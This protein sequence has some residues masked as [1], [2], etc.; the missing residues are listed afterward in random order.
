MSQTLNF[1]VDHSR[2]NHEQAS[3][4][5]KW[6]VEEINHEKIII[7]PPLL[8]ELKECLELFNN[9]KYDILQFDE[10]ATRLR[11]TILASVN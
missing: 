7:D 5:L 6:M 11:Q 3:Q 9:G 10:Q 2:A 8:F 4:I 1:E